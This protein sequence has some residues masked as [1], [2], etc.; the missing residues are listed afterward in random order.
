M[1]A[2]AHSQCVHVADGSSG[3]D[4]VVEGFLERAHG[5]VHGADG[6]QRERVYLDHDRQEQHVQHHFDQACKC[7]TQP[8]SDLQMDAKSRCWLL[9]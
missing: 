2:S 5:E 8:S 3:H 9:R 6:K 4:D 1:L 7:T